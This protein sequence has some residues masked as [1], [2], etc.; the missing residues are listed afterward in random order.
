MRTLGQ[1]N[2]DATGIDVKASPFTKHV[3]SI[4]DRAFVRRCMSGVEVVLHTAT[5]HKPHISTHSHQDFVDTNITGTL[6]LL[7]EAMSA[8]VKSFIFHE[9]DKRIRSR[10][11]TTPWITGRMD[12]RGR[13]P[14]TQKHLRPH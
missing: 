4:T 6:N 3:G 8:G 9:F 10:A 5:L 13:D 2:G 11:D 1:S 7:E 14:H 12:Y